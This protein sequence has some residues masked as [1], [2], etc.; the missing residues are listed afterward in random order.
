MSARLDE[1]PRRLK[2]R[3]DQANLI[4]RIAGQAVRDLPRP[5]PLSPTTLARISGGIDDR[6]PV[7]ARR[8][9]YAWVFMTAVFLLGAA[10]AAGAQHLQTF[11]RWLMHVV[12]VAPEPADRPA[13]S[14]SV[15]KP[16]AVRAAPP[17][18]PGGA[19]ASPDHLPPPPAATS[20][21]TTSS[22]PPASAPPSGAARDMPTDKPVPPA[23]RPNLQLALVEK[24]AARPSPAA[25]PDMARGKPAIG[26]PVAEPLPTV[27]TGALGTLGKP[28]PDGVAKPQLSPTGGESP[29]ATY[30]LGQAVRALRIEHAPAAA[31]LILDR[32]AQEL[33]GNAFAREAL[34]LRVEAMLAL[35]RKTEV[36]RLLDDT[37]LTDGASRS[38]LV[39][40]GQL[41]AAA[42][43]CTE[44]VADF[45]RVLA[46]ARQPLKP[47][48]LGRALCRKKLGDREGA[49]LDVERYRRE[50][51]D[52]HAVDGL[53]RLDDRP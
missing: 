42:D 28:Q 23:S 3:S 52:D 25:P 50:F 12:T 34:L 6:V 30:A 9:R 39:M 49:R 32:H 40:R 15:A 43:R 38:L 14:R 7:E 24:Q 41:R 44:G 10:T 2:E 27:P 21:S 31:L 46:G 36:L 5:R 48:L 16:R 33:A 37:P 45:D 8:R 20:P 22:P 47:A 1:P 51:P 26:K 18:S 19:A 29:Q 17:A 13:S 4:E 53:G 35:G 11:R